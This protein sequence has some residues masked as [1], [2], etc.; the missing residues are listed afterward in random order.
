M[1]GLA[2]DPRPLLEVGDRPL[3]LVDPVERVV[4]VAGDPLQVPAEPLGFGLRL[5]GTSHGPLDLVVLP[6]DLRGMDVVAPVADALQVAFQ[7]GHLVQG[8]PQLL[9]L[10][11]EFPVELL[12]RRPGRFQGPAGLVALLDGRHLV[13][14]EVGDLLLELLDPAVQL[15]YL[16]FV[17]LLGDGVLVGADLP[18]AAATQSPEVAELVLGETLHPLGDREVLGFPLGLLRQGRSRHEGPYYVREDN[19]SPAKAF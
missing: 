11:V 13:L 14:L 17:L 18:G 3:Q 9:R 2:R 8:A 6:S 4:K 12:D 19:P 7:T 1:G 5:L 16:V 10:A 15:S